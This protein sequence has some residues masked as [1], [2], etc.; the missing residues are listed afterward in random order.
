MLHFSTRLRKIIMS[1]NLRYQLHLFLAHYFI[2][3]PYYSPREHHE[4]YLKPVLAFK[5]VLSLSRDTNETFLLANEHHNRMNSDLR[6]LQFFNTAIN[7][8]IQPQ[9]DF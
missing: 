6:I 3:W 9:Y 8:G 2:D 4:R 7:M 1:K 5:I